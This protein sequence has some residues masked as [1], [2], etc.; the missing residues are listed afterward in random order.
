MLPRIM[1]TENFDINSLRVVLKILH[2]NSDSGGG[3]ARATYR[4]H[5]SLLSIGLDS[6]ML[7][8]SKRNQ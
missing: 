8:Q 4:L 6:K 3:A 1:L 5:Q 7:V 2:I